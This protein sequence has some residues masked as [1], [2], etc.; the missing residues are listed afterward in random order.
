MSHVLHFVLVP[1]SEGHPE[2]AAAWA[3]M[4]PDAGATYDWMAA[5]GAIRPNGVHDRMT[6]HQPDVMSCHDLSATGARV[7]L[8]GS[9]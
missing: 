8:S 1:T 5:W 6:C 2:G 4:V 3:E 7:G 9:A